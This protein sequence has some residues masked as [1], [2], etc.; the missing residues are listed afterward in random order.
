[1]NARQLFVLRG[2]PGAWLRAGATPAGI[3]AWVL[4]ALFVGAPSWADD[5]DVYTKATAISGGSPV[6]VIAADTSEDMQCSLLQANCQGAASPAATLLHQR[7]YGMKDALR[8]VMTSGSGKLQI[9]LVDYADVADAANDNGRVIHEM[10]KVGDTKATVASGTSSFTGSVSKRI[11]GSSHDATQVIGG[12]LRTTDAG[13][14]MP[15]KQSTS[16]I[17]TGTTSSWTSAGGAGLG[18]T[19]NDA[20]EDS[21][22][23]ATKWKNTWSPGNGNKGYFYQHTSATDLTQSIMVDAVGASA[24]GPNPVLF[25]IDYSA[26]GNPSTGT[27]VAYNDNRSVD[28]D[29]SQ[30][31]P[32]GQYALVTPV[33]TNP[34]KCKKGSTIKDATAVPNYN[35]TVSFTP[36]LGRWYYLVVASRDAGDSGTFTLS[37][38]DTSKG[39]FWDSESSSSS[40]LQNSGFYFP[41]IQIPQGATITSATLR[42]NKVGTTVLAPVVIPAIDDDMTPDDFAT[43]DINTRTYT[44]GLLT[45]INTALALPT[46]DV[47]SLVSDHV[48]DSGWCPG[49]AMAFAVKPGDA[50]LTNWLAVRAYDNSPTQAA[51]LLVTYDAASGDPDA[52]VSTRSVTMKISA[53]SEDTTQFADGTMDVNKDYMPSSGT[54]ATLAEKRGKLWISNTTKVGLR[55]T[56]AQIPKGATIVSAK[57]KLTAKGTTSAQ[58][59]NVY[60]IAESGGNAQAFFADALHLD[61]LDTTGPTL[62]PVSGWVDG[63]TYESPN[64]ASLV[65]TQIDNSNWASENTLG[66]ILDGTAAGTMKACAWEYGPGGGFNSITESAFGTCAAQLVLEIDDNGQTVT[67]TYRKSMV[68]ALMAMKMT[69]R[70]PMGGAYKK[71]SEYMAG[72]FNHIS[73]DTITD[74][75]T[76]DS[77]PVAPTLASGDCASNTLVFISDVN[78]GARY[79]GTFDDEYTSF[80]NAVGGSISCGTSGSAANQSSLNCNRALATLMYEGFTPVGGTSEASVKTYTFNFNATAGGAGGGGGEDDL[81][82]SDSG[83]GNLRSIADAGGG[84]FKQSG[85][86]ATLVKQLLTVL[87]SIADSGASVAAPGISVNALNRFEHLDHLY[88]SLFK[89]STTVDWTGNLKRYQLKDGKVADVAGVE[90]VDLVGSGYFDKDAQ[91]FWS[92]YVDGATV[93]I[94]GAAEESVAADRRIFTYLGTNDAASATVLSDQLLSANSAI[95]EASLGMVGADYD[96]MPQTQLDAMRVQIIDFLRA[97][98]KEADTSILWSASIHN[99]PRVVVFNTNVTVSD[100][101]PVMTVFYGDNRGFIHAVDVGDMTKDTEAENLLNHGGEE[102]FAFIPQELL[103][104][105]AKFFHNTQ[106]VIDTGYV[107]GMD[108]DFTVFRTDSNGDGDLD[109]VLLFAGMRRGGDNYY[110]LDV[111]KARRDVAAASRTPSLQWV[112]EG[113]VGDFAEMGQTWSP[114]SPFKIKWGGT[115]R[116][117][118]MFSGGYDAS[119]HDDGSYNNSNGTPFS[120]V[121][122]KGAAVFMINPNTGDLLWKS[123]QDTSRFPDLAYMKYS[124]VAAPRVLDRN[125]DGAEDLMYVVD[126]AGQVFRFEINQGA[127]TSADFISNVTLVARLGGS[128]PGADPTVDNRRFYDAPS[129]AFSGDD[130][131]L[132]LSS[133]YREEPR[134]SQT[135]E[136]L[137]FVRDKTAATSRPASQTA[138]PLDIMGTTPDLEDI[139]NYAV[140]QAAEEGTYGWFYNYD[141]S[142][143]EKGIGSPVIFDGAILASTFRFE[144]GSSGSSC[145]PDI[146][147]THL[148]LVDFFGRGL[149]G[150]PRARET[151]I[152]LPGFAD[153]PQIIFGEDGL[154]VAVGPRVLEGGALCTPGVDCPLDDDLFRRLVRSRWF[155][156]DEE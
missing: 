66:F 83:G 36:V 155:I 129:V 68:D 49:Q 5:L 23:D 79:T 63:T 126:L 33:V 70:Q 102:L 39:Q 73:S 14:Y 19:E 107:Y 136:A 72:Y 31:N 97:A 153:T 64:L 61:S 121:T 81:S 54:D 111:S 90:A 104:N 69:G 9:G 85:S 67:T 27:L 40:Q 77:A 93:T 74:A 35:S 110:A 2:R 99:S 87:Q 106:S 109:R 65:Q 52:C 58:D 101:D 26:T 124:I 147:E 146:G 46:L 92:N 133:G 103:A 113:G 53:M 21:I 118:A 130:I 135:Q 148:Y 37:M 18:G 142:I 105:S 34:A 114:V 29:C 59:I 125:G 128:A 84:A 94:G 119:I 100:P 12:T 132:A 91:S 89:P 95:T 8:A 143:G 45:T 131:V 15:V 43:Q 62:W 13:I 141:K 25:V 127:T 10:K 116:G 7:S 154:Y 51:E 71:A 134:S 151:D 11:A 47:T 88:Y 112:I 42:F 96:A 80:A 44:D 3:Y 16:T 48:D 137:F 149:T 6:V 76:L 122:H 4:S 82:T 32:A 20:I 152:K 138:Y 50:L 56:L 140:D 98:P 78:E 145:I 156:V 108:G 150:D 86:S 123:T 24:T 1:M 38:L 55:F 117:V 30:I 60:G 144:A 28:W 41:D 139:T 22:T 75:G 17:G 57:L 115:L 120:D